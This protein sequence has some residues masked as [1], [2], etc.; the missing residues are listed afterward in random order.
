MKVYGAP[1][2]TIDVDLTCRV[3]SWTEFQR[4]MSLL[5]TE[6]GLL[7]DYR[8]KHCLFD[9]NYESFKYLRMVVRVTL[10]IFSAWDLLPPQRSTILRIW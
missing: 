4:I 5:E 9:V 7:S 6:G 2:M 1:R 8:V 3:A 10:R